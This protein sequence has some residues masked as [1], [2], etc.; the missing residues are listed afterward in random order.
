MRAVSRF[1]GGPHFNIADKVAFAREFRARY[2]PDPAED[3]GLYGVLRSGRPE[4]YPEL[5]DE[6]LEQSIQDREQLESIRALGMRSVMLIPMDVGG[7]TIEAGKPPHSLHAYFMR[8]G[9]EDVPIDYHV[10]RDFDGRSFATRP[11][12]RT[13]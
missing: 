5:P 2:P 7:R 1:D 4:L 11:V 9:D 10:T 12:R 13:T 8:P 3:S 6:L